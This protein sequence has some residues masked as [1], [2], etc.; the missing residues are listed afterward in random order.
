MRSCEM[1]GLL[2]E[3][4]G[5]FQATAERR[6][7]PAERGKIEIVLMLD[8]GDV[9]LRG[10]ERASELLLG[11]IPR[12]AQFGKRQGVEDR[13]LVFLDSRSAHRVCID[14]GAERL[15]LLCHATVPLSEVLRDGR[16]RAG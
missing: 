12:R 13:A 11:D 7:V 15:E 5:D 4:R 10:R 3:D 16:H 6:G 8:A 2:R 14:W 9:R 1:D